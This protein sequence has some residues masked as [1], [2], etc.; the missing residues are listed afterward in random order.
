MVRAILDDRKSQT[1]RI[2]RDCPDPTKRHRLEQGCCRTDWSPVIDTETGIWYFRCPTSEDVEIG[3]CPQGR[4]GDKLWVR[5]TWT[6]SQHLGDIFYKAT[7][8]FEVKIP[9]KPSIH[10][11]RV[12]SRINLLVVS[13][14]VQRIQDIS[15]Q[16]AMAEGMKGDHSVKWPNGDPG[17]M[18]DVYRRHFLQVWDKINGKRMPWEKNPWVWAI[19]FRKL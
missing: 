12:D 19:E 15:E 17:T 4:I 16:D 18:Q 7:H 6:R 11:R 2:I 10:M 5:E 13:V 8:G 9:W 1:R 3:K 14:R